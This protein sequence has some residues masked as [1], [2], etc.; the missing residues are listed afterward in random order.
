MTN[1]NERLDEILAKHG[2]E[3]GEMTHSLKQAITSLI[4][5]LVAEAKIDELKAVFVDFDERKLLTTG[6]TNTQLIT[7]DQRIAQ[8]TNNR[9]S[10]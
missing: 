9:E 7:F 2:A 4:K 10:E 5:E 8:L 1:Y 6:D 3:P